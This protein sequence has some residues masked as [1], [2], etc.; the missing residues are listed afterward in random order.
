MIL[1]SVLIV[2]SYLNVQNKL[3][4]SVNRIKYVGEYEGKINWNG[5][6]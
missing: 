5:N 2:F 3:S 6:I 4:F 1:S